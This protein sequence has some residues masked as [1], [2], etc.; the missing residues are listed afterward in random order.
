MRR[1]GFGAT[2]DEL[3]AFEKMGLENTVDLLLEYEQADNKALEDRLTALN[4][5]L[6]KFNQLQ[7]W[8]L[9]R[10]VYTRRPLQEKMV[11]FWHGLLTSGYSR[12]GVPQLMWKQ[13]ELFRQQALGS[14]DVLLKAVSR[15]PAMLIWLDSRSNRKSAPNENFARELMELFSMGVGNYTE[16]D[17][18]ESARAFT[19][20]FLSGQ[21]SLFNR[22][23]HDYS[24]K[25][26]LGV[27]GD[28]DGDSVIDTIMKQPAASEYVCKRL[29]KYFVHDEPDPTTMFRLKDAFERNGYSIKAAMRALL[30]SD[31]FYSEKAYRSRPKSPAELVAG[32]LHTLSVDTNAAGLPTILTRMGQ[33]ILDPPNVAGW[34]GGP[35]WINSSTLLERVNF[36]NRIV[37]DRQ[38]LKLQE[39]LIKAGA[40]SSKEVV[41]Y[42]V[43]LLLD[44]V[45]TPPERA[46]LDDYASA[47]LK[48][49]ETDA[50]QRSVLYLILSSPAYQMA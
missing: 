8:W 12:V 13:N 47:V 27:T 32:T 21:G 25:T 50:A 28:L 40:R 18:R 48:V 26:F 37:T 15:D 9:L 42:L 35:T 22:N 24:S 23:E 34:P 44:G 17:V 39:A 46:Q 4:L 30:T 3:D 7:Q 33:T 2:R 19:G 14:Y 41:D 5:D 10:M 38:G 31:A 6:T 49:A 36:A 29:F 16:Q 1:A 45:M 43:G 11:L 20:W